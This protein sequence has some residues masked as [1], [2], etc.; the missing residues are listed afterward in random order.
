ML[1]KTSPSQKM[2]ELAETAALSYLTKAGCKLVEKNFTCPFGEIDLIIQD[3]DVLVFVE[4]RYR[5]KEDFG[6]GA[7][8]VSATKR[9]KIIRTAQ[10]YLQKNKVSYLVACRFDVVSITLDKEKQ[11]KINWIKDAFQG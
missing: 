11:F 3:Q 9:K 10:R 2:G 7:E 1:K 8:T 4:V 6:S 5:G